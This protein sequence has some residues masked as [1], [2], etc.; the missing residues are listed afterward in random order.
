MSK[1]QLMKKVLFITSLVLCAHLNAQHLTQTLKGTV[2]DKSAQYP[3]MGVNVVLLN[4]DTFT[5]TT[6]DM[7]GNFKLEKVPVGRQALKCSYIGYE[8]IVLPNI[9]INSA[10]EM[11]LSI[12]MEEKISELGEVVVTDKKSKDKAIN[13]MASVSARTIS[14]EEMTRFS[15]SIQDPARMAQNYAGVAGASDDRNDI[16]VRGNSPT[17][18]LWRL[19]GVD[20]PS[21]NHFS[22]LGTTGGPVGMLNANNLKNSDFLSSAFPA[23]Y[24]NAL[25]SVFDL[26][27]RTGNTERFEFLGQIG[28]NGFELGAEGPIG[29]GKNA[30]FMGN[31]RYST[32][33]IFSALGIDFGTGS[34]IPQYQ[35]LTFKINIPTKKAGRF[36]LW[37]LGGLSYIEFLAED[38]GDDNLFNEDNENSRFES[39]TGV[40]GLSHLYFFNNNT[41]SKLSI[42]MSGTE[43]IGDIEKINEDKS[44]TP[45]N[46]QDNSQVKYNV[47]WK[48][49]RKFNAKNR[50]TFGLQQ[51]LFNISV[52]DSV[53]LDENWKTL[54]D[55]GGNAALSQAFIQ[56][57]NRISDQLKLNLGLHGQYFNL[58]N[59]FAIEPR[60]GLQYEPNDLNTFSLGAGMHS[61]LQPIVIYFI[62]DEESG[63]T[64]N[65]DLDFTKSI[66]LA[67]GWDRSLNENMRI[68]LE[69]YCQYL[70][71]VPV[72]EEPTDFSLLNTGADF[73]FPFRSN[74][75]NEG[76]GENY[77]LELTI[78]KFFSNNYYFLITGSVFESTYTGSDNVRRNTLFNTNYVSNLLVGKEF[79][80]SNK[81]SITI[82]AKV[83]YAGG[84]RY[85]PILLEES[86]AEGE[87]VRDDNQIFEERYK[88]YFRSDLKIGFRQNAKKISQTFSV[89]L[90]NFTGSQNI[91][92]QDFKASTNSIA[93]T[94]QRGFFPDV[95]Y[96]ILF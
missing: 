24:G 13:E 15:G 52:E 56:Y 57:Q 60:I 10:K 7:D 69:A 29:I 82:D 70:Y 96:Q 39:N 78:E 75:I 12:E 68:K 66:H 32:L 95:R 23:E 87:T 31:Y 3:L 36:S 88:D 85:T 18:V 17:G 67:T 42:A 40:I 6:T 43:S 51:E 28:F 64:T 72:D 80:L 89:D 11:V 27:L 63:K 26:K 46:A 91:F 71:S 84:R 49:N 34:A 94:Y 45:F 73:G 44:I 4:D 48:F 19:E 38:N 25:S 90:Q 58:S 55:F 93:T 14:I 1:F 50:L 79:K 81:F 8:D 86:I 30:S 62:E 65:E 74:L 92:I 35:D 22:A 2:I 41:Y 59:S 76:T 5:A 20:I 9:L 37:G 16:I 53:Y 47:S 77:G 21:P 33:S 54:L 83:T 61:Q